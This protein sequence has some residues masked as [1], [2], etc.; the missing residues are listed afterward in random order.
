MYVLFEYAMI[1]TPSFLAYHGYEA[2]GHTEKWLIDASETEQHHFTWPRI[3]SHAPEVMSQTE[4]KS[5]RV[6]RHAILSLELEK[7]HEEGTSK[8]GTTFGS[9]AMFR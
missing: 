2:G 6:A 7:L 9:M 8:I 1:H 3:S 5:R 4:T